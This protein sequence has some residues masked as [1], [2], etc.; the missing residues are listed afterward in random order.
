VVPTAGRAITDQDVTSSWAGYL[1][2]CH[3]SFIVLLCGGLVLIAGIN[4]FLSYGVRCSQCASFLSRQK[5]VTHS[6]QLYK[7][8][9]CHILW[10]SCIQDDSRRR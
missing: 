9:R 8:R 7:C 4:F 1:K 6:T 10:N 3:V 2:A 5:I